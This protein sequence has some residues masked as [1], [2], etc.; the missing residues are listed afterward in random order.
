MVQEEDRTTGSG[1]S[2][3][4]IRDNVVGHIFESTVANGNL[5]VVDPVS[6]VSQDFPKVIGVVGVHVYEV[7][8]T[9][10]MQW[11]VPAPIQPFFCV[12]GLFEHDKRG[13]GL[14]VPTVL[15]RAASSKPVDKIE[16]EFIAGGIGAQPVEIGTKI[17]AQDLELSL[18]ML[19]NGGRRVVR[20]RWTQSVGQNRGHVKS[21][22]C[23]LKRLQ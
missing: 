21:G 4:N 16:L 17:P 11:L 2:L 9:I 5:F 12:P 19:L 3:E 8:F 23:C 7:E 13:A 22:S 6:T 1:L 10:E 18:A 15:E 14:N 20:M